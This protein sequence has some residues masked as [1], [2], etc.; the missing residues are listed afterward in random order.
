MAIKMLLAAAWLS[1]GLPLALHPQP[2]P[3]G[4]AF[5]TKTVLR[6][7]VI[8][9]SDNPVDQAVKLDVRD[10]VLRQLEPKLE[11]ASNR[12]QAIAAVQASLPE[13][14]HVADRVLAAHANIAYRAHVSLTTTEFPA[15]AYGSTV[16]PAGRYRALLVVL[17]QGQG[18]NW[19]CVLY[20]TL[21]FI[22]MANGVAVPYPSKIPQKS[23]LSGR[24]HVH[25]PSS[26]PFWHSL[27]HWF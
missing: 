7:R 9:N 6:F 15:K 17:G 27:I 21:C 23:R 22:D 16:L 13:I 3:T 25:W 1:L 18:H 8:A 24:I 20:P 19:W 4:S 14:Q 10:A 2:Q 12:G 5:T 11:S 26:P